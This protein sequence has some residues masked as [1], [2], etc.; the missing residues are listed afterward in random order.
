M[1]FGT[2]LVNNYPLQ[3]FSPLLQIVEATLEFPGESLII[4]KA[5]E[6]VWYSLPNKLPSYDIT[7]KLY[8]WI[9][10]YVSDRHVFLVVNGYSTVSGVII[11]GVP[12]GNCF[13]PVLSS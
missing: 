13:E 7:L 8:D 6:M 10:N 5:F 4:S 12:Q 3:N 2:G 11:D 9:T 1:T